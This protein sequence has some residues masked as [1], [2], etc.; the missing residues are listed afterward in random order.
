MIKWLNGWSYLILCGKDT[1]FFKRRQGWCAK[2]FTF[3]R[4]ECFLKIRET[5]ALQALITK[6]RALSLAVEVNN[7]RLGKWITN[8]LE[9]LFIPEPTRSSQWLWDAV[10]LSC[11]AF[12]CRLFYCSPC[13]WMVSEAAII[14]T[15]CAK[16][17]C[18]CDIPLLWRSLTREKK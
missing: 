3:V 15:V 9:S 5:C 2:S 18:L 6:K 12:L 4:F 17:G 13:G 1:L 16:Q 11:G 10:Q 8:H 14:M 7:W